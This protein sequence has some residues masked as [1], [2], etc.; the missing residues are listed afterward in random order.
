MNQKLVNPIHFFDERGH[1][2]LSFDHLL[3]R[4][5]ELEKEIERLNRLLRAQ[6]RRIKEIGEPETT[7][8]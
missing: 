2:T 8:N 1:S 7:L 4:N 6:A 5:K 3:Q